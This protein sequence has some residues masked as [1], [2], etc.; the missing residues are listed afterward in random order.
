MRLAF[1][2]LTKSNKAFR[3]RKEE[4]DGVTFIVCSPVE[5]KGNVKVN[6]GEGEVLFRVTDTGKA[7]LINDGGVDRKTIEE[8]DEYLKYF[9]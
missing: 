6:I 5:K 3:C 4:R 1:K 2:I 8:L 7:E 9:L